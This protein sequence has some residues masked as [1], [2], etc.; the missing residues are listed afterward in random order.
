MK[1][2]PILFAVVFGCIVF[3]AAQPKPQIETLMYLVNRPDSIASFRD[4]A[5][6][7]SIIAPQCFYMDADGFV[8]GEVPTEVVD[9]ARQH[10][11]ALMPLVVNK[12]FNQTVMHS[13]LDN[14]EARTRAIRYLIYYAL[15]DGYIGF[16]FDY[17]NIHYTYRDKY[18]AFVRE[19]AHAFHHH[20]LKL[21]IA[22]VG[23]YSDSP[24]SLSPG[25]YE[26]W[27]GVYDYAALGRAAD[28]LSIMAYPEHGGFSDPGPLASVP[29]VKR[30]VEYSLARVPA[31]KLSL[32]VPLYGT[33]WT[34]IPPGEQAKPATF[35]QDNEG[36]Q[37]KKWKV[38]SAPYPVLR[39]LLAENKSIWD[40][41]QQ[42]NR[43]ELTDSGLPVVIWYEDARS[44]APK[45]ALSKQSRMPGISAWVLGQ[46]DPAFWTMLRRDYRIAHPKAPALHGSFEER[47]MRAA[48]Q[49][50]RD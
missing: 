2:V 13:V 42:S 49:L 18:S 7:V 43:I 40:D 30:V 32:G 26:N 21:S 14:P 9:V 37:K 20:G 24:N 3:A 27:S 36:T 23:K 48:R 41:T 1:K 19:A 33:R 34:S 10:H 8:G 25:G 50:S 47:A 15:R 6:S 39:D 4:Q 16:Q 28:F 11:V 31:R 45:L 22:V 38:N 17:E 5:R 29:W 44:L 12:G 46:E 35:S